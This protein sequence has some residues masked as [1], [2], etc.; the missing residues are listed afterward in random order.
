M[1]S[2]SLVLNLDGAQNRLAHF[3]E[4]AAQAGLSFERISAV[5]GRLLAPNEIADATARSAIYP[6]SPAEV[7]CALS[8]RRAWIRVLESGAAWGAIFED[9]ACLRPE[10][11]A[12]LAALPDDLAPPTIIKLENYPPLEVS[13]DRKAIHFAGRR[14]RPL[15]GAAVGAAGYALNS[16]AC[17][18]LLDQRPRYR[19]PLDLYLFSRRHGAVRGVT[20]MV[21]DPAPVIQADRIGRCME[22]FRVSDAPRGKKLQPRPNLLKTVI[23]EAYRIREQFSEWGAERIS[24]EWR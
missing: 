15:R 18:L 13:V 9:D 20:A 21:M 22:I 2:I 8:H 4:Q 10:T 1:Q 16:A 14:L 11:G 23:R 5:D 3:S 24:P 12:I 7:G 17:R 19:L 6:L